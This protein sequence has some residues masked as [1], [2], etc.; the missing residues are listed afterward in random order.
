MED[1]DKGH[2]LILAAV[3]CVVILIL[4]ISKHF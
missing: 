4:T 2:A 3:V 1:D